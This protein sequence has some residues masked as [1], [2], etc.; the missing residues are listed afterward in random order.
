MLFP[1]QV[2]YNLKTALK[3]DVYK[4]FFFFN[5]MLNNQNERIK[6]ALSQR[7]EGIW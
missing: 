4:L 3:N 2:F 7:Q 1:A 6:N 5:V